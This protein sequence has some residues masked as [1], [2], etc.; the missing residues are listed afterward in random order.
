HEVEERA[1]DAD[2]ILS[3]RVTG[4]KEVAGEQGPVSEHTPVWRDAEVQVER[5]HKGRE[6]GRTVT[7][8]FPESSDVRWHDA[9]KFTPGQ[10][11]VF[12]LHVPEGQT[13]G[14][15]QGEV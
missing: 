13:P 12:L 4:V 7:V 11:G 10:E 14:A 3:G 9:P 5:V 6:P 2:V 8:R 1:N 15:P